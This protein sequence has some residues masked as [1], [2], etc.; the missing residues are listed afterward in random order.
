MQYFT[1]VTGYIYSYNYAGGYHLANQ[2]YTNCVRPEQGYC[3]IEFTPVN[4]KFGM[5]GTDATATANVGDK[6]TK[7]EFL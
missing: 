7:F 5:S 4:G 1:G 6:C 2:K 3:S